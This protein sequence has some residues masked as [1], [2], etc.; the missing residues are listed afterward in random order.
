MN[1]SSAK[2]VAEIV[3]RDEHGNVK[4]QGPLVMEVVH[5]EKEEENGRNSSDS[6]S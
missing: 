3:V 6:G 2:V 5:E 1:S 4:Y